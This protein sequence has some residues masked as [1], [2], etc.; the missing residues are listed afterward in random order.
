MTAIVTITLNPAVDLS[1]AVERIVPVLKLRGTS[2]RRDPGGGGINVARVVARLG[3]DVSAIYLAGGAMGGAAEVGPGGFER[4]VVDDA[5]GLVERA[6]EAVD[7]VGGD[8]VGRAAAL[9][10]TQALVVAVLEGFEGVHELGEGGVDV[11]VGSGGGL[12]FEGH[13]DSGCV[14]VWPWVPARALRAWPG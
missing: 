8:D 1:T 12:G 6:I 7:L 10:L 2:Q 11:A 3:G 14:S 5:L 9:Q 4:Q 13:W